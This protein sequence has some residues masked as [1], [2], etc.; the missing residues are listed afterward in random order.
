MDW[1]G[2]NMV[3]PLSQRRTVTLSILATLNT[4]K[5]VHILGTNMMCAFGVPGNMIQGVPCAGIADNP[6]DWLV[7]LGI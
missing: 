4:L 1:G 3:M 5:R 6:V 7:A 2:N